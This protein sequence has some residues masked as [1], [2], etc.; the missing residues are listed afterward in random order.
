MSNILI[1]NEVFKNGIVNKYEAKAIPRGAASASVNF[2]TLLDKVELVRG[3]Q[4]LGTEIAGVGQITGLHTA[5]TADGTEI[6]YKSYGTNVEY[7]DEST[8]DWVVV[9][10]DITEDEE[11]AFSN[12][13]TTAGAQMWFSTKEE[14]PY[15]VMTANPADEYDQYDSTKNFRGKLVI[16]DN[17]MFLW[18]RTEDKTGLYL[19]YIDSLTTTAVSNEALA[20]VGQTYTGTLAFKAA[21]AKR[22]CY[23]MFV[24]DGGGIAETF[25]DNFNGTLTSTAGGTG[26]INYSTGAYTLTFVGTPTGTVQADYNWEDATNGGIAD[27]TF[28]SPR[29][30]G[31]GAIFRQDVGGDRIMNVNTYGTD[32]YSF[33]DKR[34]YRLTLTGDDTNATNQ[35]YRERAG[36]P[37]WKSQVETDEGIYFIDDSTEYE[38]KLR[39]LRVGQNND[40][41]IPI[42]ATESFDIGN[43]DFSE[44]SMVTWGDYVAFTGKD[45]GETYNNKLFLFHRVYRSVDI[46]DWFLQDLVVYNGALIGGESISDNV[47]TLFSGY[48]D[49]N[50]G[51]E[52]EWESSLDN[53]DIN[54]LKKTKRLRINGAIGPDQK[55]FVYVAYD[56]DSYGLLIDDDHT[57]GAIS[58]DGSYVDTSA[59]VAVGAPTLGRA[60]AGGGGDGISAYNYKTEFKLNSPKFER[61]KVKFRIASTNTGYASVSMYEYFS[62]LK[63]RNKIVSKYR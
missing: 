34:V 2:L 48:D 62:I 26:T 25:S 43:Y 19:S 63:K 45:T 14:G 16:K 20:G 31:E 12:Y 11:V 51:Y 59:S 49:D 55:I 44:C 5:Q 35:V 57:D 37:F 42:S 15:K 1:K 27:F 47:Y 32:I 38:A 7:Y 28:S 41:V 22:T 21:G 40:T 30:A 9:K 54:A 52:A 8:S 6:L 13:H 60:E 39:I 18:D 36:S 4:L 24:T 53:L 33:K 29:T 10:N 23:G 56:N 17:R 46:V 58:G 61:V 3:R 50:I